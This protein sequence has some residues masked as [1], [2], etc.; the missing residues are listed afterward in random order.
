MNIRAATRTGLTAMLLAATIGVWLVWTSVVAGSGVILHLVLIGVIPPMVTGLAGWTLIRRSSSWH[1]PALGYVAVYAAEV[2][3]GLLS[4]LGSA[5]YAGHAGIAWMFVGITLLG[6]VTLVS[7]TVTWRTAHDAGAAPSTLSR[8][9]ATA[10]AL[11]VTGSFF[12]P[13]VTPTAGSEFAAPIALLDGDVPTRISAALLLIVVVAATAFVVRA[14]NRGLWVGVV[15]GLAASHAL[16]VA[17]LFDPTVA[18]AGAELASG[19][20]LAVAGVATLLL[21]VVAE[22]FRAGAPGRYSSG[23]DPRVEQRSAQPRTV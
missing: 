22:I 18:E 8:A 21:A 23:D 6:A 14:S 11:L 2:S 17:S 12:L 19:T 13:Q 1:L 3:T 16:A 7:A 20:F 9:V 5:R 4:G 15:G 10:G